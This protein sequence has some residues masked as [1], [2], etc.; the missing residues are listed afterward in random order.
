MLEEQPLSETQEGQPEVT[1]RT[2]GLQSA[3]HNQHHRK[4]TDFTDEHTQ[5]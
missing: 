1:S 4:I 5:M 3:N 2:D